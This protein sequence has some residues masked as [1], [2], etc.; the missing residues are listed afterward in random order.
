MIKLYTTPISR[1]KNPTR[2]LSIR[3]TAPE[4]I[5]AG[6]VIAVPAPANLYDCTT[7]ADY[8][9]PMEYEYYGYKESTHSSAK[10]TKTVLAQAGSTA[11]QNFAFDCMDDI[12]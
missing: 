6:T 3:Y 11:T 1:P 9:D 2:V 7:W 10:E 5:P 8:Y 4:N 12:D